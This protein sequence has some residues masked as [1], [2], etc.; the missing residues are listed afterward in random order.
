MLAEHAQSRPGRALL[1]AT[2]VLFGVLV[3]RLF[4]LQVA[5]GR[6]YRARSEENRIQPVSL[7]AQR[8]LI[9][10]RKGEVFAANRPSYSI[11]FTRSG[12]PDAEGTL[13][14]LSRLIGLEKGDLEYRSA[15]RWRPVKLVRDASFEMVSVVEEHRY[16]LPGVEIDIEARRAY[17]IGTYASH[18]IGYMGEMAEQEFEDLYPKGYVPGQW[19]GR[20]G[21]ERE[22][23]E[24]LR[25]TNGIEYREVTAAGREIGTLPEGRIPP[26]PGVD[27]LLALDRDLQCAAEDAFPDTATGA[28]VAL[29]PQNGDILAMV[30]RPNFDPRLFS[31]PMSPEI[32]SQMVNDPRKPL[33]NR[34]VRGLYPPAST[35]K[36]VTAM[37]ALDAGV[38]GERWRAPACTGALQFGDRA[39][40]CWREEGHGRL[41]LIQGIAQSCD[42]VFY[43]LGIKTGLDRWS[44]CARAF[45]F[46][47]R[48][49]VDLPREETGLVPS[50]EYYN[51][52]YGPGRWTRG[53]ML[54]VAIGQGEILVTP[55]QMARYVGAICTEGYLVQP[56]LLLR[57]GMKGPHHAS[58]RI[59]V[60]GVPGKTL[61]LMKRAML[62]VVEGEKGTAKGAYI[63]GHRIAGKTGTAQNHHGENHSWFVG[64]A[65][66]EQSSIAIAVVVEQGW[67]GSGIATSIARAVLEVH[68]SAPRMVASL[69]DGE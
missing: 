47:K 30:S 3:V 8:G 39:Y 26:R 61:R 1:I 9:L 38:I 23:E 45:E 35:L 13:E 33:L 66:F 49:G 34:S 52:R 48:A 18:V 69:D 25:G 43:H 32:W 2:S 51:R 57:E 20:D 62:E 17:P 58:R 44:A 21:V 56:H 14:R 65:P 15:G 60:K 67:S 68:L 40:G 50:T 59:P 12:A 4:L 31:S 28:L 37:A 6:Y 19:I 22:Y 41:D 63:P 36:M 29:N 53:L 11:M 27:I 46:G 10:D 64:F 5:G 24:I 16:D 55:L 42:V 7:R 54:N